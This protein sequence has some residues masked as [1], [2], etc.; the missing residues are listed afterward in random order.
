M[1]EKN[2]VFVS[3]YKAPDDF[4]CIWQGEV[5]TNFASN[6]KEATHKAVEKLFRYKLSPML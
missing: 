2:L 1:S 5:K 6:R 4:E 3:E